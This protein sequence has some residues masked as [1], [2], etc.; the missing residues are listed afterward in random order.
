M[1]AA[2]SPRFFLARFGSVVK[3]LVAGEGRWRGLAFAGLGIALAGL[4]LAG[5]TERATAAGGKPSTKAKTTAGKS[6][7]TTKKD[8]ADAD[9][10]DDAK[11]DKAKKKFRLEKVHEIV[12]WNEHDGKHHDSGAKKCNLA[13]SL[14]GKVVWHRDNV[15]VPWEA[16]RSADLVVEVGSVLA[17]KLRVEISEW[18][19]K[20]GGLSEVEVLDKTGTNLA[21]GGKVTTSVTRNPSD[22]L[23]GDAL[24]DGNYYEPTAEVGYWLLPDAQEG[25]AELELVEQ[26]IPATGL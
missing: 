6:S 24:I 20:G 1:S 18:N 8:D 12:L 15:E 25:W 13:L 11:D 22:G 5:G 17:D 23:D 7:T 10:D 14:E 26:K 3:S 21:L 19:G 16:N 9:D 4:L 2:R